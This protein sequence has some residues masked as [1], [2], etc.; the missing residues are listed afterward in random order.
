MDVGLHRGSALSPYL[1]LIVVDVLTEWVR[2]EVPES[3]TFLDDIP[4]CAGKEVDMTEY[5]DPRRTWLE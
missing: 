5:Q 4:I 1:L 3:I 2:K